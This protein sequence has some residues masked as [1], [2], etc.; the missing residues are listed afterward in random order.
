M[1]ARP[2]VILGGWLGC[3]RRFLR[4]YELLY[5]SLGFDVFSYVP[6]PHFVVDSCLKARPIQ[7]PEGWPAQLPGNA[8]SM[9]DMAWDVLGRIY[10]GQSSV[11]LFHSF[12]N[13]GCFLWEYTRRILDYNES[14]GCQQPVKGILRNLMSRIKGVV[15]DSCPAWF[16]GSSSALG[17]ALQHCTRMER[18]DILL[19][20]GPGVFFYDR[21]SELKKQFQ[22]CQDFFRYLFE[23]PLD[24]PQ[25]Y[26]YSK[27]DDLARFERIK[28]LCLH[29]KSTQ[30]KPVLIQT[31]DNS[32]HCAH[33]RMHPE[34][35]KQTIEFFTEIML[36]RS[37]L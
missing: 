25:L 36:L 3:Q 2:L 6:E 33:L 24:I 28:E 4:R 32:A 18:L 17:M 22:R 15:F 5:K 30:K 7:V 23:D 34:A 12:S 13:G 35:Y 10:N 37:K 31:W 8:K 19:R 9:Q 1:S 16:V 27:N 29:R 21:R 20:F 14:S 26:I 11:F